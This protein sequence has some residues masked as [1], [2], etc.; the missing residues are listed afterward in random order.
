MCSEENRDAFKDNN[1]SSLLRLLSI[2]FERYSSD[3]LVFLLVPFFTRSSTCFHG[4][5]L[6]FSVAN[7]IFYNDFSRVFFFYP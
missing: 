4:V 2:H 3:T 1:I 5:S 7:I 6:G